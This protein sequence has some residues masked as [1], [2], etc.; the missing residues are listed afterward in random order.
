VPPCYRLLLLA[1]PAHSLL[2]T[3]VIDINVV[4]CVVVA[5]YAHAGEQSAKYILTHSLLIPDTA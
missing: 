3:V 1:V 5:V 2:S 4:M